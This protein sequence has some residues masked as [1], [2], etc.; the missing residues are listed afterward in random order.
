MQGLLLQGRLLE[1]AGELQRPA[2]VPG[3]DVPPEVLGAL[4]QQV[5]KHLLV[6]SLADIADQLEAGKLDQVGVDV[7]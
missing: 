4:L 6:G 7:G 2:G 3:V 5:R 1:E